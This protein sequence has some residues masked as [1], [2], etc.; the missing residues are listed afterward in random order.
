MRIEVDA[1][2]SFT[3]DNFAEN[4]IPHREK[5]ELEGERR[6]KLPLLSYSALHP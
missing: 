4:D 1:W 5:E 3:R 2:S 6:D